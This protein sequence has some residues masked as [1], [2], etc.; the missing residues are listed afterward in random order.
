MPKIQVSDQPPI[1]VKTT[2]T[3]SSII[4]EPE[5]LTEKRV[6]EKEILKPADLDYNYLAHVLSDDELEKLADEILI[7]D[8]AAIKM[9]SLELGS[10]EGLDNFAGLIRYYAD[11]FNDQRLEEILEEIKDRKNG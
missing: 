3:L 5:R 1:S 2:E 7:N 9:F 8:F 4:E 6:P 11:N 10:R